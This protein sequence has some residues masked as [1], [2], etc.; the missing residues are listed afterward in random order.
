MKI[1]SL[2]VILLLMAGINSPLLAQ[3]EQQGVPFNGMVFDIL[4]KPV[5]GAKIYITPNRIARSDKKGRFGLTDVNPTDTIH[6]RYKKVNYD[7]PVAGRKSIRITLGD[8]L[9][10]EEDDELVAWGYG[11]VKRRESLEVSNGISGDELVRSGYNS[12]LQALEGRIPG[13]NISAN[14]GI[15]DQPKVSMRGIN[16]INLDQTPLFVVDGVVVESLD[17]VSIYEVDHVEV[18]KDASIYGSRG[19]NGAIIVITKRGG[20]SKK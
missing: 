9:L 17:I 6:V 11:F 2:L 13:L 20:S 19:A 15:G 10:T 8:Q 4:G 16:S 3:S 7:I 5:K 1:Y 12:I 18:L 14:R